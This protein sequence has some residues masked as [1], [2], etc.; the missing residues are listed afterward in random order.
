MRLPMRALSVDVVVGM[1]DLTSSS[2]FTTASDRRRRWFFGRRRSPSSPLTLKIWGAPFPPPATSV[3]HLRF[4]S[5]ALPVLKNIMVFRRRPPSAIII[6]PLLLAVS[7][8]AFSS[9]SSFG[10]GFIGGGFGPPISLDRFRATCPADLDAVRRFDPT[11]LDGGSSGRRTT[12]TDVDDTDVDDDDVWVAV[13]R[14]ANNLPSVFIRDSFFDAMRISTSVGGGG[15]AVVGGDE[16]GGRSVGAGGA[17]AGASARST[18]SGS[19]SCLRFSFLA[20]VIA[21]GR[22]RG[23]REG[24]I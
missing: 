22:G 17:P 13:Y 21:R 5:P 20:C 16:P 6:P 12:S 19:S 14:S 10:G 23:K 8:D 18:G 11:L 4:S 24:Y 1:Y 15:G 3:C 7:A 2:A 9:S